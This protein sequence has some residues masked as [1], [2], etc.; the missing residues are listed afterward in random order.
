[1]TESKVSLWQRWIIRP[2]IQQL[3]Q[4]V[5]PSKIAQAAAYGITLGVFPILGSN[6]LLTVLVGIPL[7]LNQPILQTFKTLVYP[8]QWTS[9]LG[10][11]RV[12]EW[13]FKAPHVSLHIPTMMKRFFTEPG[14]F[15][16]DYGMTAFYGITVWCLF[17]PVVGLI[18]Y[19]L[20]KLLV[21]NLASLKKSSPISAST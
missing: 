5:S 11:Y 18:I 20:T 9:L 4:G 3:T 15:F 1:M 6:T 19:F 12:G 16:K 14:P 13:L 2:I 17:A 8:L 21:E 10:F 7:R